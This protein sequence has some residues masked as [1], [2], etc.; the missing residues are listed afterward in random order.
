[1]GGKYAICPVCLLLP[2][3]I[4]SLTAAR[5][6]LA[7]HSVHL[8]LRTQSNYKVYMFDDTIIPELENGNN[9]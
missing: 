4:T 8:L 5:D 1:M 3:R 7:L 2:K 9:F 6:F